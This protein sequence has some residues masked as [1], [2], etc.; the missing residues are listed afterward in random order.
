M[1]TVVNKCH[2]HARCIVV[3]LNGRIQQCMNAHDHA[4][5]AASGS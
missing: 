2:R 5:N 3:C 1:L 4:Y